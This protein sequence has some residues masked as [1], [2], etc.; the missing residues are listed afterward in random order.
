MQG[1]REKI[2]VRHG[3]LRPP[4]KGYVPKPKHILRFT[5]SAVCPTKDDDIGVSSDN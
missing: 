5:D 2:V 3:V 4:R 1:V